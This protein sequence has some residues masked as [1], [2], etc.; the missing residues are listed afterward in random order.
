M[1]RTGLRYMGCNA[2]KYKHKYCVANAVV[3]DDARLIP[4]RGD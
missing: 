2:R 4:W 3:S 1:D